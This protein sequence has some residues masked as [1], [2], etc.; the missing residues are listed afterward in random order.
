MLYIDYSIP[1]ILVIWIS[2]IAELNIIGFLKKK[3]L[4]N[5]I[6]LFISLIL[7]FMHLIN[8]ELITSWKYCIIHDFIFLSISVG[9][10]LYVDDIESR[11]KVISEVFTNRYKKRTK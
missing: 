3:S 1:F 4:F 10:Y 9:L 8:K 6:N 11:R 2:I 5:C 7:I